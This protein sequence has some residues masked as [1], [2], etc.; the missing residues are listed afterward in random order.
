MKVTQDANVEQ[1]KS[2]VERI[3]GIQPDNVSNYFN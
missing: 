3:T 2:A 1:L